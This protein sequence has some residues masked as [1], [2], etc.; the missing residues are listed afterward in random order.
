MKNIYNSIL[1]VLLVSIFP[2]CKKFTEITPKG[3]NILN[4]VSDLDLL[5]NFNFSYNSAVTPTSL[6]STTTANTAFNP[7]EAGV[8]VND[9]YPY[10]TNVTTLISSAP[11]TLY[12]ALT[13]YN[14]SIDRKTIAASDIKYEKL[15]FIINNVCNVVL[16]NADKASGDKAKAAQLKAEAYILRAYMHYL[17]VNFYAKAYNPATAASDGGI[18]YVKEDNLVSEANKKSTVAEVYTLPRI[19]AN[20]MRVGQAFAYG[21]RAQVLLAMRNY[22]GAL[23]AANASLAINSTVVDDRL[24]APVGTTLFA[25]PA[26]ISPDNLFYASYSGPP[27]LNGPSLEVLGNYEPGNIINDYIKPYYPVVSGALSITGVVD[28][29]LWYYTPAI[30]AVNTAGLTTSDTYLIKAECLARTLNVPA[31]MDVINYIRQRRI[32]ASAYTP[33]TANTEAQ[34]MAILKKTARIEFLYTFKN[35]FNIKRWNTED[36]Y[37]ETIT[38]TVNGVTYTL[39]PESPLYIFPFPISATAYNENLTQN[40]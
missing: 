21:V 31:A 16:S 11:K 20:N 10:V 28:A 24:Y 19:P 36:A 25:K 30:V 15:Y 4:R 1:I 13:T 2:A 17:L 12:Y 14:E 40:Y 26:V 33:L 18:P 8:I 9:L 29:K 22:P 3:S 6:A 39:K 32:H 35:Y 37:K 27:L 7:N 34:A 5:M 23:V 38:R